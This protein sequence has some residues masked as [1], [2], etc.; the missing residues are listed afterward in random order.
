LDGN[1]EG[2]VC[3]GIKNNFLNI[4]MV[5]KKIIL[6][7]SGMTCASCA[8]GIKR[9]LG[10]TSGITRADINFASKKA[11]VEYNPHLIGVEKILSSVS[12]AGY[13]GEIE[14]TSSG[15]HV[16][17]HSYEENIKKD[18]HDF[19]IATLLSLPLIFGMIKNTKSGQVFFGLDLVMWLHLILSTGIVWYYGWRFHKMAWKL[20]KR[21]SANMDTLISL[22]TLTAYFYSL[23]VIF[24]GQEGYLETASLIVV[25]ILLGKYFEARSTGKASGAMKKLLAL[26]VEKARVIIADREEEISIE[27]IKVGDVIL[28]KPGEK[29]PLDGEVIAGESNIDESMLTGESMPVDKNVG[30]LVFGATMNENGTLKIKVTKTG[31]GTVLAQIIKTVEEAQ[32]TKAPVERLA[33]KISGFFV[34]IVLMTAIITFLGWYMVTGDFPFSVTSA[35]AVLIVACPCALGLA[36]PTAIMVG[37]G[38][39]S[40]KGILFKN[41]EIFERA[42]KITMVVFDKTG[43]LTRGEPSV[44]NI[45]VNEQ[46]SFAAENILAI[47]RSLAK[48]STHPLSVALEKY[49]K[50]KE[51]GEIK[52]KNFEELRGEGLIGIFEDF[53][54]PIFLGNKKLLEDKNLDISWVEEILSNPKSLGGSWLFVGHDKKVIGAINV[55]DEIRPEAKRVIENL[56]KMNLRIGIIT[57]DNAITARAVAQKLGVNYFRAEVL[58]HEKAIEIKKLQEKYKVAFVGDGINDAPSLAQADL[59]IA[60][61]SASDIA[62][63]AGEIILLQNN[64]EKVVEAIRLSRITFKTIKQNLFWAFFYNVMAI[65][66]AALG[67]LSPVI[68]A[69]AMS[70]SSV[71]VVANSLRI[72]RK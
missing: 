25:F 21:L 70:F 50:K 34:P 62:K 69:A 8:A 38:E 29:I 41:P 11:V 53:D 58:P 45:I 59:G 2:K 51:S 65:P 17:S 49:A 14:K 37:T 10:K 23:V 43:T 30:S 19:L 66:L 48:N 36:T 33:D 22:G 18:W 6:N 24:H 63:E 13:S 28:V 40:E 31:E 4:N 20:A 56:R 60:M 26:K 44:E 47:A 71:S 72:Y 52:V 16:H 9:E 7:I 42:K 5:N 54:I 39:G 35:I 27:K 61:G 1:G 67:F 12:R 46:Y 3:G 68:A 15:N 55:F 32:M 64:L 57:G